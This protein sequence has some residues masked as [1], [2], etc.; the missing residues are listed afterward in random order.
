MRCTRWAQNMNFYIN[1]T[2][3]GLSMLNAEL[4]RTVNITETNKYCVIN[5]QM[6]SFNSKIVTSRTKDHVRDIFG[7]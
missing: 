3:S 6:W 4:V 1:D 7:T 5:S 2:A